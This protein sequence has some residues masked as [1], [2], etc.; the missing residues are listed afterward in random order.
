MGCPPFFYPSEDGDRSIHRNV[1]D[2]LTWCDGL[3]AEY[4]ERH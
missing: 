2:S 4:Q 3:S 1:V